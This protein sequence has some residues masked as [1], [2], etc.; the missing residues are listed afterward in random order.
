MDDEEPCR[1]GPEKLH[2]YI[3]YCKDKWNTFH[4]FYTLK[5]YSTH[6]DVTY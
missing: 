3:R 6:F 1:S 4:A 5:Q 2:N